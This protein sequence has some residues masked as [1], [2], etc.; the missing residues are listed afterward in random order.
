VPQGDELAELL[1]QEG[2]ELLERLFEP[3]EART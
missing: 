2:R 3:Q 1:L